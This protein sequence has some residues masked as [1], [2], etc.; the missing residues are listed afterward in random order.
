L[1]QD[2]GMDVEENGPESESLM[3]EISLRNVF[4]LG[5]VDFILLTFCPKVEDL[6]L[7]VIDGV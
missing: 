1:I 7:I 6:F 3:W 4:Y 5:P 2:R